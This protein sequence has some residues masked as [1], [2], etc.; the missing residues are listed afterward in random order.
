M[1]N[2]T[3]VWPITHIR[4]TC[5]PW[6]FSEN[7]ASPPLSPPSFPRQHADVP[8]VLTSRRASLF[9]FCSLVLG[10][11]CM[12]CISPLIRPLFFFFW[13]VV[14]NSYTSFVAAPGFSVIMLL[15]TFGPNCTPRR[16]SVGSK[17]EKLLS[18]A[19]E[20]LGIE[21]FYIFRHWLWVKTKNASDTHDPIVWIIP[22]HRV[23]NKIRRS[24]LKPRDCIN[25]WS[26][27][28]VP[29]FMHLF[30]LNE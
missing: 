6:G 3:H 24:S 28:V 21:I 23:S 13:R 9:T 26:F 8:Y 20:T 30:L 5:T 25:T 10:R 7:T 2:K 29:G 19:L 11:G 22:W 14:Y 17:R 12:V 4:D 1:C 15:T 27:S 16:W 18:L